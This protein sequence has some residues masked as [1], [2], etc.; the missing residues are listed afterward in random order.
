MPGTWT[1]ADHLDLLKTS[2]KTSI[3]YTSGV[4]RVKK[5]DLVLFYRNVAGGTTHYM[6]FSAALPDGELAQLAGA[7]EKATFGSEAAKGDVLDEGVRK[8]GKLD[9]ENFAARLEVSAMGIVEAVAPDLLAGYNYGRRAKKEGEDDDEKDEEEKEDGRVLRAELYKLNAQARFSR[10]TVK[11]TPRGDDMIGSLVIVLPTK[12]EGGALT[13]SQEGSTWVFDSASQLEADAGSPVVAYIAF[14]SDVTHTVEP[15]VSGYRVTL[16]YNLFLTARTPGTATTRIIPAPELNCETS[17]RALLADPKWL[18]NGG[19]LA[20]GLTH[21]YPMPR[22]RNTYDGTYD[23]FDYDDDDEPIPRVKL[24]VLDEALLKGCDARLH[25]AALRAGLQPRVRLIYDINEFGFDGKEAVVV[26]DEPVG[27]EDVADEEDLKKDDEIQRQGTVLREVD[28][29]GKL[30]PDPEPPV[31]RRRLWDGE[32][33]EDDGEGD[34]E[35]VYWVTP[36]AG[37]NQTESSYGGYLGNNFGQQCVYG[38]AELFVRIPKVGEEGRSVV[39][40][41][42]Q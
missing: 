23:E 32:E 1:A 15:V 37:R 4:Q 36:R 8:A 25:N 26:M 16:T 40:A 9:V 30:K 24:P 38:H 39:E 13:L 5:E 27:V 21:Q 3:P 18:P 29:E 42:E 35:P 11:D 19:H 6:D 20:F 10:P 28:A 2:L 12:H 33:S 22:P 31:K 41:D 14:F 7:C 17:L 34:W